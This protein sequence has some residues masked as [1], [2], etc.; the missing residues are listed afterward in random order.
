MKISLS[1]LLTIGGALVAVIGLGFLIWLYWPVLLAEYQYQFV[2]SKQAIPNVVGLV[3]E[4]D[5]NTQESQTQPELVPVNTLF[6]ITIPK[7]HTSAPLIANVDSQDSQAYQRALQK[8]VAHAAGSSVPNAPGITFLFAHSSANQLIAKQYNAV[9]YLLN[10]MEK[11]D[12]ILVYY[13]GEPYYYKVTK[14]EVVN[15]DQVDSLG[16]KTGPQQLV[17]MTC[18]PAGTTVRR[19]LVFADLVPTN[20][21]P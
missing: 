11:D 17:L 6:S 14:L 2:W 4:G 20:P 18:T 8:G 1:R 7:L 5:T 13:N 16:Q 10:K 12:D 9:F 3:T 19:L 21:L 15:P